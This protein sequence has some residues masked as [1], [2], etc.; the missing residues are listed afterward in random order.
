MIHSNNKRGE[1]RK[2]RKRRRKIIGEWYYLIVLNVRC[3]MINRNGN[4]CG[5]MTRAPKVSQRVFVCMCMSMKGKR[6][7]E[8]QGITHTHTVVQEFAYTFFTV[9]DLHRN[10]I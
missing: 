1:K 3:M 2:R 8:R 4:R 9:G 10:D 5:T 6:R 7:R